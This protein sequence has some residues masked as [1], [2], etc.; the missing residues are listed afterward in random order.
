MFKTWSNRDLIPSQQFIVWRD[1]L[2]DAFT[3]LRPESSQHQQSFAASICSQSLCEGLVMS[4]LISQKQKIYRSEAEINQ[5]KDHY[6]FFNLQ[7][8]GIASIQQHDSIIQA[9]AGDLY[10]LDTR[11]P[12][13][14]EQFD[15]EWES[16]SLRIPLDLIDHCNIPLSQVINHTQTTE[17]MILYDNILMLE[18]I[19]GKEFNPK[20]C[21]ILSK[22][23]IDL[24]QSN[25]ISAH[26]NRSEDLIFNKILS[27]I[28]SNITN[29]E[30]RCHDIAKAFNTSERNVYKIF[31]KENLSLNQTISD[32]R[33]SLFLDQMRQGRYNIT[34]AAYRSGFN[35][36]SNFYKVFKRKYNE[37]PKKFLNKLS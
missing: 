10:I 23:I 14:I 18:K 11:Y 4:S 36:L 12:Y 7:K 30:L 9:Q 33:L 15:N 20:T 32:I 17:N 21:Q 35:D 8:S 16:L 31:E 5:T 3:D 22:S 28:E 27:F 26:Y 13:S 19:I 29:H 1:M 34:D 37:S 6:L 25:F 24:I 2:C